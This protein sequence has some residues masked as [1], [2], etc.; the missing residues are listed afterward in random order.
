[1]QMAPLAPQALLA[2]VAA[3]AQVGLAQQTGATIAWED[4]APLPPVVIVRAAAARDATF[5]RARP[6]LTR[7]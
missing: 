4:D 7:R 3:T 2:D 6:A 1:M 5:A